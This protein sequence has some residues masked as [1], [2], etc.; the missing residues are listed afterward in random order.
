M[1]M[2]YA[3]RWQVG[4]PSRVLAMAK[5]VQEAK[6]PTPPKGKWKQL[7]SDSQLEEAMA[8][9][10]AVQ[11]ANF[12]KPPAGKP[13]RGPPQSAFKGPAAVKTNTTHKVTRKAIPKQLKQTAKGKDAQAP[14]KVLLPVGIPAVPRARLSIPAMPAVLTVPAVP[15]DTRK[16]KVKE[17]VKEEE[18]EGLAQE[19]WRIV[20]EEEDR[21]RALYGTDSSPSTSPPPRKKYMWMAKGTSRTWLQRS[22][23]LDTMT[24]SIQCVARCPCPQEPLHAWNECPSDPPSIKFDVEG[25]ASGLTRAKGAPVGCR[26]ARQWVQEVRTH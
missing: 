26:R 20:K 7:F 25:R 23:E 16:M 10:K 24:T 18:D 2:G 17:E 9:A 3:K 22:K 13:P 6:F 4:E 8:M 14:G 19:V 12:P 21:N 1:A 5:A 11:E 15:K